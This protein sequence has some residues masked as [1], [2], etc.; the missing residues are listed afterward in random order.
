MN[1]WIPFLSGIAAAIGG[2]LGTWFKLRS[3]K[4][5]YL[6]NHKLQVYL[7]LIKSY[8]NTVANASSEASRQEYVASQEQAELIGSENVVAIS[9]EFYDK[10]PSS[11]PAIQKRLLQAMREDLNSIRKF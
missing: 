2:F 7:N 5:Q 1:T 11:S 3:E 10:G 6:F 8:R 9:K 4:S